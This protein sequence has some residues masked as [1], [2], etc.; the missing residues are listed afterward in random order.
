MEITNQ[1][2]K[3]LAL[4]LVLLGSTIVASGQSESSEFSENSL[5]PKFDT[6]DY[7]NFWKIFD[8]SDL[9]EGNPFQPYLDNASDGLKPFVQYLDVDAL[10]ETV[11]K[12]KA[13]YLASRKVLKDLDRKKKDVQASYTALKKLYPKAVFPPVYFS[14]GQFTS[15][16]TLSPAGLVIGCELLKNL[17]GLNSLISHELVHY[18][19]DISGKDSLL[20]QCLAEGGADFVGELISGNHINQKAFAYGNKHEQKLKKEFVSVML[21]NDY[22]DWLYGTSGKDDRPNDLGYWIGYKIC[23][24]YSKKQPTKK[25]AVADVLKI[26]DPEE[27][28]KKSGYLSDVWD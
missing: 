21:D 3:K 27:F 18:Q 23:E 24:A 17:D 22:S 15:G 8:S 16:G 25:Q 14:V 11:L 12:R 9:A 2:M 13:D 6:T 10:Y 4:L 28:V 5:I 26:K 19:Q 7:D 20:K 1:I